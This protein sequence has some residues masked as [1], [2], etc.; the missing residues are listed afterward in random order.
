[1]T[2]KPVL[3]VSALCKYFGGVRALDGL[4]LEVR[5]GEILGIV[6]PNGA[7]K[8]ALITPSPGSTA[9]RQAASS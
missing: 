4:E 5:K 3:G 7:G 2:D 8:T 6:G 9:Q 1:M